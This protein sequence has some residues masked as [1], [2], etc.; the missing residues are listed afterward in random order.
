MDRAF[1]TEHDAETYLREYLE[2]EADAH[3]AT[4]G[5]TDR[6]TYSNELP[7]DLESINYSI[8]EIVKEMRSSGTVTL[9]DCD[10]LRHLTQL[11]DAV[12][13][14]GEWAWQALVK[15]YL[16]PSPAV[17]YEALIR[18]VG[19]GYHPDTPFE[20]YTP[21]ISHYSESEWAGIHARAL[22]AG[23]DLY[24]FGL[25]IQQEMLAERV[26]TYPD[27]SRSDQVVIE[28]V[29]EALDRLPLDVGDG[30]LLEVITWSEAARVAFSRE[31]QRRFGTE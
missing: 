5:G 27:G 20:D 24:E 13:T 23:I 16:R 15:R 10:E 3:V 21:P 2:E 12:W 26:T 31:H 17:E 18:N 9:A 22:D 19:P 1:Q 7:Y 6:P 4:A 30:V 25:P 14:V 8:Y 29:E 11:R 28:E